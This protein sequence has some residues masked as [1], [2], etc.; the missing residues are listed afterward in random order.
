MRPRLVL[1][2]A[3][4]AALAVLL[5]ALPLTLVLKRAYRGE[6]ILRLQRD[7]VAAT[8]AI[9]LGTSAGDPVELP[10]QPRVLA[11]YD[12][13]G[14]RI[15]GRGGPRTADAP[16]RQALRS[17]R[18][19][20]HD[21][22]GRVV[23]AVPLVVGERVSGAVRAEAAGGG[24]R[25]GTWWALA[26]VAALLIALSVAAAIVLARRLSRPL[27][28]LADAA[29]RLGDGDFAIRAP[30]VGVPEVDEVG[31]ALDATAHRLDTLVSR[32]RSFSADA[33]HQLR[34][35]LAA[36][37]LELEAIELRGDPPPEVVAAIAQADRLQQTIE[38]LLMVARDQPRSATTSDLNRVLDDARSRWEAL[39]NAEG[40]RLR[41][42]T[43]AGPCLTSISPA[44]L[45]EI[46]DVLLDNAHRHGD[47]AV[48]IRV[49][50]AGE[51]LA[52]DVSDEGPGIA[53]DPE[54]LFKRRATRRAN[55][56][57]GL[58]LARS[59]A[60]AEGARLVVT[61]AAPR[62]VFTLLLS[63]PDESA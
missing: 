60:H 29:R 4:V 26:G 51:G 3:G 7:T 25:S 2:I 37:R 49:R 24:G 33:S 30:R 9:D 20:D 41:L 43:P 53:G 15:R 56:G 17:E 62:A 14:R 57:I 10:Q 45:R 52:I 18:L 39:L 35:P 58:A 1:A 28:R 59:L 38:T 44:V 63:G 34:T 61:R 31:R 11:V 47:G 50:A 16:V 42:H 5:F 22:N 13:S 32:E 55:H 12:R 48:D 23:I 6:D 19:A 8:R 21:S 36:L 46:L 27:E 40:R 54:A